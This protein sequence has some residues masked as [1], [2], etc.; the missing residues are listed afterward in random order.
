MNDPE[1]MQRSPGAPVD[2]I[3]TETKGLM[4]PNGNGKV[5]IS[6]FPEAKRLT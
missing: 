3:I 5:K 1:S 4:S 6:V 2:K